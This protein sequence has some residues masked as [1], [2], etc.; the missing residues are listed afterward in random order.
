[1]K[2]KSKRSST[3][4]ENEI[5]QLNLNHPPSNI[6]YFNC[7]GKV[8]IPPSVEQAGRDALIKESNPWTEANAVVNAEANQ[9]QL[10]KID[11]AHQTRT[12]FGQIIGAN[13]SDVAI[14]PSTGFALTMVAHNL[15]RTGIL[16]NVND[17]N[18]ANDNDNVNNNSSA[19]KND[20][21][22]ILIL[23][24]EMSSEVYC[25]QEVCK[26]SN[27]K[28]VIVPHPTSQEH[29][30]TYLIMKA[31]IN[32]TNQRIKVVCI[33][34]VH[35]SDGSYIDLKCIGEECKKRNIIFVVDGTQS[36]GIFPLNVK[37]IQCHVL[38]ASV[39][40]WLLGPHGQSLVYIDPSFHNTW[41][42]LDQHERS[43][44]VF[45][46][47]VYDAAEENIGSHGYPEEFVIGAARLD[48][49]GKKNPIL[50]PMVCEGLRIVN[51][52]DTLQAQNYLKGLTNRILAGGQEMGFGVQPGPRAGHIIGLRP[53]SPE[54]CAVLTP[55]RM[56][57][58]ANNLK[59][60]GVYLAVRCGA[61]RIAPYLD[62]TMENVERLLQALQEE[63]D[64]F[65]QKL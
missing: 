5:L 35:W 58:M 3:R 17:N 44:T 47:D 7:A 30:W 52:I 8:P 12:L 46:N 16:K 65:T 50:L 61:F 2:M 4:Y 39:H 6:A 45:Q 62:T 37:E 18:N 23:Q 21:N 26:E 55:E 53:K 29:D 19:E 36:V 22:Q 20:H 28:L 14:T 27:C 11:V 9:Q 57:E 10:S 1:M 34:Q 59:Q 49:G 54:L 56:V 31:L 15:Y 48:S 41:L 64:N 40:K 33:P 38:A 60:K 42:P 24:D 51:Q 63:C 43:R 13:A 25:W 32:D